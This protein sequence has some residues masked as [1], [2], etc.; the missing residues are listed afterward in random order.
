MAVL[1]VIISEATHFLRKNVIQY[2]AIF[3]G[4]SI[5]CL[6][7]KNGYISYFCSKHG[8]WVPILNQII[9]TVLTSTHNLCLRA[10]IRKKCIPLFIRAQLNKS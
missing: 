1:F 7:E 4:C 10:E 9:E 3:R 6:D 2:A 8:L 5:I